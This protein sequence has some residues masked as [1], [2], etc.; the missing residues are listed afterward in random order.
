MRILFYSD[1][2]E[3]L[4]DIVIPPGQP[5][6]TRRETLFALINTARFILADPA[7]TH[8]GIRRIRVEGSS[9]PNVAF[10]KVR[11]VGR[12]GTY[13]ATVSDTPIRVAVIVGDGAG[14]QCGDAI[15]DPENCAFRAHGRQLRCKFSIRGD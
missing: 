11:V 12:N 6:K 5:W 4:S 9:T 14:R 2:G 10:L 7:G 8:D 1:D 13:P 15:Y 3:V